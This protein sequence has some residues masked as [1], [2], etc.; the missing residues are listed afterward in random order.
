M[1]HERD[2]TSV[3]RPGGSPPDEGLVYDPSMT[4]EDEANIPKESDADP[5]SDS[6]VARPD[7]R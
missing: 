3:D 4:D 7:D 2:A 1:E 5:E 6:G